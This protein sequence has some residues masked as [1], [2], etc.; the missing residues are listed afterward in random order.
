MTVASTESAMSS[1]WQTPTP[2]IT[3]SK[4]TNT[5]A[6]TSV[7]PVRSV[8]LCAVGVEPTLT[9]RAGQPRIA[10]DR[11]GVNDAAPLGLGALPQGLGPARGVAPA[12]MGQH[13]A[14]FRTVLQ[15]AADVDETLLVVGQHARAVAVAVDL[16]QRRNARVPRCAK[17][18]RRLAPAPRCPAPRPRRRPWRAARAP[19]AVS[20]ARCRRRR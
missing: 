8:A 14:Q 9:H 11:G 4:N 16:D 20:L 18:A 15:R 13:A 12:G 2:A 6:R 17:H 3:R 1:T 5:P 10:Q 19:A 7:T